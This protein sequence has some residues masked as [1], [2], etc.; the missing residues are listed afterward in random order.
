MNARPFITSY[1]ATEVTGE[2]QCDNSTGTW[3]YSFTCSASDP[4]GLIARYE[5]TFGDNQT[6]VVTT[7]DTT[8]TVQHSY[9]FSVETQNTYTTQCT[10]YDNLGARAIS[11]PVSVQVHTCD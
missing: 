3:P 6:A 10:V 9:F 11:Q 1:T 2:G 8:V 7:S 5:I 4:E